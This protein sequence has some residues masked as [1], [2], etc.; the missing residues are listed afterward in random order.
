V[1]VPTIQRGILATAGAAH[2]EVLTI[3]VFKE[4]KKIYFIFYLGS[5]PMR[6]KSRTQGTQT[7]GHSEERINWL[8]PQEH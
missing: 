4:N 6:C 5:R 2:I 3:I 8:A 1:T 7:V